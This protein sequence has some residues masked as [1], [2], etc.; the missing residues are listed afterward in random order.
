MT[1]IV[2]DITVIFMVG[3]VFCLLLVAL[4]LAYISRHQRSI[5]AA[6]QDDNS[7]D[8]INQLM[9]ARTTLDADHQSGR[10]GDNDYAATCLD[11]DRRLLGLSQQLAQGSASDQKYQKD[12]T[13]TRLAFGMAM[14]LP[15]GV[16]LIYADLGRPDLADNPLIDR[17]A[18]IA[19]RNETINA[20]KENLA[21]NLAG[22][23][24]A[25][26]A[27]P[28]DIESWL[29]LAEAAAVA[30]DIATEVRALGMAR[31]LTNDDPGVSAGLSHPSQGCVR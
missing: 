3:G 27:T 2:G 21:Q 6:D 10:L 19:N 7:H 26:V 9:L 13:F 20:T 15:L 24:A 22:A 25:T 11:I 16:A 18:E 31:Q 8:Q 4:M 23:Q 29:K 14:T 30:N 28:D 5:D 17:T 1:P 12:Q